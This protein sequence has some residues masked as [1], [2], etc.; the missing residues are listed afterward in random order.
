M[1]IL[2]LL[3]FVV[4]FDADS[5]KNLIIQKL[6]YFTINYNLTLVYESNAI[7]FMQTINEWI[8]RRILIII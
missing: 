1:H 5:I 3:Y 2:I 6:I 4:W 8:L 7:L